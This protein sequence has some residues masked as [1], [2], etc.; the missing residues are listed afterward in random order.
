MPFELVY[1]VAV[2]AVAII[3]FAFTLSFASILACAWRS[4]GA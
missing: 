1:L 2:F 4:N 3:G